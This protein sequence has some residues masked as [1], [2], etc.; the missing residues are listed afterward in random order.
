MT[1]TT[2]VNGDEEIHSVPAMNRRPSL[3][4]NSDLQDLE[5]SADPPCSWNMERKVA[6]IVDC[7]KAVGFRDF[8]SAVMTYYTNA[9]DIMSRAHD[10]QRVSRI[11]G[12]GSV[13]RAIDTSA[14]AW[15][16]H[17]SHGYRAE[18]FK[19]AEHLYR[20]ELQRAIDGGALMV[21]EERVKEDEMNRASAVR[22]T[23]HKS[24]LLSQVCACM[25]SFS[26]HNPKKH[27]S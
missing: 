19:A 3:H 7:A 8:D 17:E 24:E 16:E 14:E 23:S 18:I 11:R 2:G 6:Y 25:Y 9:F 13:L 1:P 26:I 15:P 4:P 22:L 10:I 5:D 27:N 12:L 21:L 20:A